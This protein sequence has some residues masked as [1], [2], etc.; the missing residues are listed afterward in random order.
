L[1]RYARARDSGNVVISIIDLWHPLNA[2]DEDPIAYREIIACNGRDGRVGV[3]Y[4][5]DRKCRCRIK[6]SATIDKEPTI[7]VSK[8]NNVADLSGELEADQASISGR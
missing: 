6:D 5:S 4:T 1:Q 3:G 8:L 7:E 2:T